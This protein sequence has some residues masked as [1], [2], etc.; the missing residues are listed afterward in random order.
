MLINYLLFGDPM[1]V[2]NYI[3]LKNNHLLIFAFIDMESVGSSNASIGAISGSYIKSSIHHKLSLY[4]T[5]VDHYQCLKCQHKCSFSIPLAL[6]WVLAPFLCYTYWMIHVKSDIH[7]FCF[8]PETS[9]RA[10]ILRWHKLPIF[11]MLLYVFDVKGRPGH[12]SPSV[13]LHLSLNL[14]TLSVPLFYF[15]YYKI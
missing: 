13:V 14:W 5:I 4:L 2:D 12:G 10:R 9:A 8:F 6:E 15:Q 11:W 1:N 7:F 3:L